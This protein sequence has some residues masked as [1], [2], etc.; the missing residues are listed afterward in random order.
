MW[1]KAS[2]NRSAFLYKFVW[3]NDMPQAGEVIPC[4]PDLSGM[5][6]KV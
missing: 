1:H 6:S 4:V 5:Y 2:E 3:N